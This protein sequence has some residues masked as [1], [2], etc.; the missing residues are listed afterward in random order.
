MNWKKAIWGTLFSAM[1]ILAFWAVLRSALPWLS[2]ARILASVAFL[3]LFAGMV[4]FG[5]SIRALLSSRSE[6]SVVRRRMLKAAFYF[7]AG[8]GWLAVG[9]FVKLW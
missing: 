3:C 9:R 4:M 1:V 2:Y 6:P 5:A 8:I 7:A